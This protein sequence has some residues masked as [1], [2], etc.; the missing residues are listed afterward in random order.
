MEYTP[1]DDVSL[2]ALD[3]ELEI[4][5]D[6]AAPERDDGPLYSHG[7]SLRLK[8]RLAPLQAVEA[9]GRLGWQQESR[10]WRRSMLKGAQRWSVRGT[11][12]LSQRRPRNQRLPL[13]RLNKLWRTCLYSVQIEQRGDDT[14]LDLHGVRR[15]DVERLLG[16]IMMLPP[17]AYEVAHYRA[18][19]RYFVLSPRE[20]YRLAEALGGRAQWGRGRLARKQFLVRDLPVPITVRIR[21]KREAKLTIYRVGGGATAQFKVEL[22]L[23][24]KVRDRGHFDA[25]DIANLDLELLRLIDEHG[26]SPV[27]KPARWEPRSSEHC[28]RDGQLERLGSAAYRGSRVPDG[29]VSLV[30]NCHTPSVSFLCETQDDPTTCPAQT[31]IRQNSSSSVLFHRPQQTPREGKLWDSIASDI[32]KYE[33]YLSEVILDDHQNPEPLLHA[34]I[35]G[36]PPGGVAIGSLCMASDGC[37]PSGWDTVTR[38]LPYYPST[39]KTSTLVVVIDPMVFCSVSDAVSVFDSITGASKPGPLFP[40]T[41]VHETTPLL[42]T[43]TAAWLSETLKELRDVCERTGLRVVLVTADMRPDHGRGEL[44]RSHF[45]RDSRVRSHI[46]DAGRY[47]AHLRYLVEPGRNGRPRRAVLVK[48][49][50]E[51]LMGRILL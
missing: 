47:Y 36:H 30:R 1:R 16:T 31:L 23:A 33:G 46:G 42:V 38:M 34:L 15:P 11:T 12:F 5:L 49:E 14:F 43:A 27:P 41:W 9:L 3:S 7:Y 17:E 22:R 45:F 18:A 25:A 32:V 24:G 8:L 6:A 39:P 20:A 48:D 51:G 2:G 28:S 50:G 44:Q 35:N 29:I 19:E 21:S 40:P 37:Y 4:S 13:T 26:L 10:D